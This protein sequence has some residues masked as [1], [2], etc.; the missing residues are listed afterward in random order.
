MRQTLE[1][2]A[3]GRRPTGAIQKANSLAMPAAL[4][5][6]RAS[7]TSPTGLSARDDNT[8]MAMTR[9]SSLEPPPNVDQVNGAATVNQSMNR[10]YEVTRLRRMRSIP[11]NTA[12]PGPGS[13]AGLDDFTSRGVISEREAEELYQTSVQ[14][15]GVHFHC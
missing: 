10:F 1:T 8:H 5:V 3:A 6:T 12:R 13:Q 14:V 7:T 11:T 2:F 4:S 15:H 9:Q